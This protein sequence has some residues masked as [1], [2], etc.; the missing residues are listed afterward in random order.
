MR[1]LVTGSA[2][3]IGGAVVRALTEAGHDVVGVDLM[4][5]SA[6][7]EQVPPPGTLRLDVRRAD[8]EEVWARL[9][10]GVDVVCH[11]A[12]LV[13]AGTT[14]T[15]LPRY[16]SHNDVG[17]AAL[18]AAMGTHGVRRLV[19]ASSMVV[20]GEGSYACREHGEQRPGP[21][22]RAALDAGDFDHHCPT[23]GEGLR[24]QPVPETAPLEPRSSYA[25]S[26]VAQ[27]HY[28]SAWA[29]QV[30]GSV[31]ALRYHNV[32]GPGMPRDTPYSGVA[33]IFRSALE[34]GEAPRVL[35]DGRQMRDFV[36]VDD[37]ARA[38]IAAI[39]ALATPA[40]MPALTACNIASGSPIS[41]AEVA[42]LVGGQHAIEPVVTGGHRPGDVRHVVASP[43]R[44]ATELGFRARVRPEEGLRAFAHAPLR[45]APD[46]QLVLP[47]LDEG[48]ALRELLPKVPAGLG[49]IVV[50]NGS[51]DDTAVVARRFGAQVVTEPRRGYGAA[52]QAGIEA[53]TAPYLLVM[54][55][56]GSVD[57]RDV[58]P[59]VRQVRAGGADLALGYRVPAR[60]GVLPWHARAGNALVLRVLRRRTGLRLRDV[61]PV[62][63]FRREQVLA[64]G[65]Q[66]RGMG[67][68][69][70][71]LDRA[72]SAGWRAVERPVRY[73]PRAAGTRSKVSGSL[74][75]TLRTA[76]D[77]RRV[78]R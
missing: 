67:Y 30:G 26:K 57:P 44:A 51:T 17:T 53:A 27:E 6:H 56:D 78:L 10:P 24:W 50:D 3:F 22:L 9:L 33:A 68:P 65:V 62:R 15:D 52:V 74:P 41:I 28:A 5:D 64:L 49:V 29:R 19:L 40:P 46:V 20:Y 43:E 47:C 38:N 21:R 39:D 14:V 63:A 7:G 18:L 45:S 32:Y 48:P 66:D 12:A 70:E 11:Q 25:A 76:R 72:G 1:V 35:E 58:L 77:F 37:V 59:L 69:L 42:R 4:L 23:C 13:G 55:G 2:G 75:G 34:R 8:R 73:R 16:A 36:H 54:D 71:L 60:R 31:V 61:G